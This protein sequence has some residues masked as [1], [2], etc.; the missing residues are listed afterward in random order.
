MTKNLLN[1]PDFTMV[2]RVVPKS[3]FYQHLEVN[4]RMKS[5]FVKNI[6][7]VVWLYKL[8]PSNL[9]I[10]DGKDVHEI[11]VFL[12]RVKGDAHPTGVKDR[13]GEILT[14]MDTLMPR[15][16]LFILQSGD[17]FKLV[18][19]YK[20]WRDPKVGTFDI[21]KTFDTAW[22]PAPSLTLS[23]KAH[24]TSSGNAMASSSLST[25]DALYESM[26]RQVAAAQI[27]SSRHDLR[28]A[29]METKEA[30]TIRRAMETIKRKAARE[31]QP[32]KKFAWHQ[33]YL[34][35][36]EKLDRMEKR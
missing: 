13:L 18:V 24:D 4:A 17:G 30:E 14:L 29:V 9:H 7:Q 32:Q 21:V 3:S 26:V 25:M 11:T 12:I 33:E 31:R 6:E 5:L 23:M 36:K 20:Q 19:N 34:K 1:F 35:L 8:A 28:Q 16:T 10:A 15:H 27:T 22:M 2:N